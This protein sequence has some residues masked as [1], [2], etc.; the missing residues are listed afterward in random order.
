MIA[1]WYGTDK[2]SDLHEKGPSAGWGQIGDDRGDDRGHRCAD[3]ER[4]LSSRGHCDDTPSCGNGLCDLL[5]SNFFLVRVI[6]RTTLQEMLEQEQAEKL[7]QEK[8]DTPDE[9]LDEDS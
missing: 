5:W 2:K 8:S 3:H 6:L 9:E 4:I 1:C 7:M